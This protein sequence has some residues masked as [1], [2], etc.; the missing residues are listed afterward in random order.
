MP[1][2]V[3]Y[4]VWAD[5]LFNHKPVA[6]ESQR[7]GLH[8]V[9]ASDHQRVVEGLK[10]DNAAL[11]S[12]LLALGQ[13]WNGNENHRAMLDACENVLKVVERVGKQPHPGTALL[14]ELEESRKVVG[15]AKVALPHIEKIVGG[16]DNELTKAL[17]AYDAATG[18]AHEA[19]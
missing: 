1:E 12:E 8:V 6:K 9:D 18:G 17:T 11:L 5:C 19:L 7:Q 13:Y 16:A 10:A 4:W 3:K 15:I 14:R 2:T